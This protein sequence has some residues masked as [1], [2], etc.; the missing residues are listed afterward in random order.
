MEEKEERI[1]EMI[2][3]GIISQ[4]YNIESDLRTDNSRHVEFS[5]N[6]EV[7]IVNLIKLE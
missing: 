6:G 2:K 5:G 4:G 3:E 1:M 7:Y